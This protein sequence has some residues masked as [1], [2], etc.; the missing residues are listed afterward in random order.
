MLSKL[1]LLYTTNWHSLM[2][3][4]HLW[5]EPSLLIFQTQTPPGHLSQVSGEQWWQ[6][7]TIL[8]EPLDPHYLSRCRSTRAAIGT[9][10]DLRA[11]FQSGSPLLEAS[12]FLEKRICPWY[13]STSLHV[14]WP[15][16]S[17]LTMHLTATWHS[18]NAAKRSHAGA[19]TF[20][21]PPS[22]SPQLCPRLVNSKMAVKRERL[23]MRRREC[24]ATKLTNH[25][26][27]GPGQRDA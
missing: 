3:S 11:F 12:F 19:N 25:L 13:S 22:I 10:N 1:L 17:W 7:D 6:R 21:L 23:E 27:Y 8:L 26:S 15:P 14:M 5:A 24:S 16:D 9:W 18:Y 20:W 4:T 2:K